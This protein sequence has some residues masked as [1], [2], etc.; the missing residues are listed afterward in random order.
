MRRS[1]PATWTGCRANCRPG[2]RA[3]SG[4][5]GVAFVPRA[6][7]ILRFCLTGMHRVPYCPCPDSCLIMTRCRTCCWGFAASSGNP[8]SGGRHK[9]LG[10]GALDIPPQKSTIA[11]YYPRRVGAA[12]SIGLA[13]R[14]QPVDRQYPQDAIAFCSFGDTSLNRLTAQR[15]LNITGRTAWQ[16]VPLPLMFL[17]EDSGIGIST[18]TPT[19]W[20]I[21]ALQS[22][23][24]L[25]YFVCNGLDIVGIYATSRAAAGPAQT[26]CKTCGAA[27]RPLHKWRIADKPSTRY[28][29]GRLAGV[30]LGTCFGAVRFGSVQ[31]TF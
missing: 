18:K 17:C 26:R 31:T 5:G 8:I 1:C 15:A 23:T 12:Y 30:V 13:A 11:S 16:R 24:G 3:S 25:T 9:V 4:H 20:V 10:S 14:T 28:A 7:M 22:R 21:A 27:Q 29:I 19:G 2:G 6:L